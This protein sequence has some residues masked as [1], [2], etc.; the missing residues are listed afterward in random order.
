M[1]NQLTSQTLYKALARRF[2]FADGR[3]TTIL[4]YP[5]S[6]PFYGL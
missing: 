1:E 5:P 6:A 2:S 3:K 4:F